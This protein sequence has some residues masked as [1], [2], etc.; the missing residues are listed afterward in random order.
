MLPWPHCA[1]VASYECD[2]GPRQRD[3]CL[4]EHS[5]KAHKL[6]EAST[7]GSDEDL[8]GQ[9]F[10]AD[11][12]HCMS[13]SNICGSCRLYWTIWCRNT[14]WLLLYSVVF[15]LAVGETLFL[16]FVFLSQTIISFPFSCT[17]WRSLSIHTLSREP[18]K[19]L[20]KSTSSK[21]T[22]VWCSNSHLI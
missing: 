13:A 3:C 18:K 8:W 22:L 10:L 2:L 16:N 20:L 11:K 21:K 17:S 19:T 15:Q 7:H 1:Y 6:T 9:V 4:L 12:S 14:S 5:V